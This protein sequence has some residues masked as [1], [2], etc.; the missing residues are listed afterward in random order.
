MKTIL[1]TGASSGIGRASAKYFAEK[2]WNVVATMRTP[3]L[4]SELIHQDRTLVTALDVLK[5]D[6][7]QDAIEQAISRFGQIDV[8][9]NNAG[10]GTLGLFEAAS[11]EQIERQFEVNVFGLMRVTKAVLPHMRR[12]GG[13]LILNVSSVGG[14]VTFPVMSL[15]HA[16]KFAVEG[17]SESLSFELASQNIRVKLIEPG[18]VDTEFSKKSME[19]LVDE[20]LTSYQSYSD[21]I[22]QSIGQLADPHKSSTPELVASAIYEAAIDPSDQLRYA[23]GKDANEMIQL[24][25]LKGSEGTMAI[26]R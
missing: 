10:Y 7:I 1:I 14:L 26:F 16:T 3:E 11:F 8:L 21:G 4:E 17:F 25:S 5:P 9:L 23:V 15:Y 22:M 19:F 18:V 20:S 13:G 24:R 2:G 6:T 12:Q